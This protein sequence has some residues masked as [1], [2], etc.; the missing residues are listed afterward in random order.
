LPSGDR[1]RELSFQTAIAEA[2][3][4]SSIGIDGAVFGS[5]RIRRIIACGKNL[6][7]RL[8]TDSQDYDR[9]RAGSPG[10][11]YRIP[12]SLPFASPADYNAWLITKEKNGTPIFKEH[13]TWLNRIA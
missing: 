12:N 13:E 9:L 6:R 2:Y 4:F 11:Q 10:P 7:M 5:C 8:C 3:T 1:K